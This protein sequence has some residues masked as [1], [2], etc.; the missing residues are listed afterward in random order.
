[1]LN[2]AELATCSWSWQSELTPSL[3]VQCY[4]LGFVIAP[5]VLAYKHIAEFSRVL[6]DEPGLVGS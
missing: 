3:G 6:C 1:M 2:E 4:H 5:F